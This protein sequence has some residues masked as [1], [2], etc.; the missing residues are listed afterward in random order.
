MVLSA[1]KEVSDKDKGWTQPGWS[2][3]EEHAH[4]ISLAAAVLPLLSGFFLSMNTTFNPGYKAARFRTAAAEVACE[5]YMYRAAVGDYAPQDQ[6]FLIKMAK[7][8]K[9]ASK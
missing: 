2:W 5:L 6:N 3:V 8:T 7:Q 4:L 1:R 9:H